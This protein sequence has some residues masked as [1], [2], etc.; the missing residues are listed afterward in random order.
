MLVCTAFSVFALYDNY[1]AKKEDEWDEQFEGHFI[2]SGSI[3][4][5]G[6]DSHL[7]IY[8]AWLNAVMSWT[9]L[10][11]YVIIYIQSKD[12]VNSLQSDEISPTDFTL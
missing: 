10:F 7:S 3:A 2:I 6:T 11:I 4:A 1:T 5:H 8:Q 9:C 12:I